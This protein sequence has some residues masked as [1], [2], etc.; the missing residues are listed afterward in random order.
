MSATF[1]SKVSSLRE[2]WGKKKIHRQTEIKVETYKPLLWEGHSV[3]EKL[4][5][6]SIKCYHDTNQEMK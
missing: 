6:S 3:G 5:D 1:S 2:I 4:L